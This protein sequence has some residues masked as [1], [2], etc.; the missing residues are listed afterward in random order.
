MT[1]YHYTCNH[2]REALGNAGMVL[3]I[4]DWEPRAA[5]K[6]AQSPY[7]DLALI[8]WFTDLDVPIAEALGLTRATILCDRTKYRYRVIDDIAV[9]PWIRSPHRRRLRD[10]ERADGAMP[11]HWYVSTEP[12]HVVLDIS[13]PVSRIA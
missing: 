11:M 4:A 13:P 2:G 3:P 1:I 7:P 8:S 5:A 12:V 10:L 6:L 9:T